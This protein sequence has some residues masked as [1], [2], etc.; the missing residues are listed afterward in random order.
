[1][2][3]TQKCTFY[4]EQQLP[5]VEFPHYT[6]AKAKLESRQNMFITRIKISTARSAKV[7]TDADTA[8]AV[9]SSLD[10]KHCHI[11]ASRVWNHH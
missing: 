7:A 10:G 6:A 3:Y 5:K 9:A 4:T 8:T 1:M 2:H 11:P